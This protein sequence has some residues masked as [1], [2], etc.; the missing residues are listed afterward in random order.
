MS[1]AS[2]HSPSPVGGVAPSPAAARTRPTEARTPSFEET[3]RFR[4]DWLWALLL[5]GAVPGFLLAAVAV[6]VDSTGPWIAHLPLPGVIAL[7]SRLAALARRSRLPRSE[8]R[9]T[10]CVNR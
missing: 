7:R 9:R 1:S 10:G 3:Q 4:Q 8:T 5:V 2:E 6:I